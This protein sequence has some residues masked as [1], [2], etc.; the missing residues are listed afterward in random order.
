LIFVS[1]SAIDLDV[2]KALV[3]LLRTALHLPS[4][5]I[6]CT[7]VD[8]NRLPVGVDTAETLRTEI[9]AAEAFIGIVTPASARSSYV[10]FELGA[11]WGA[12]RFI[13][14]VIARG[15]PHSQL[16]GPLTQLNALDLTSAAQVHQLLENLSTK[17]DIRLEPA[18]ALNDPIS[19]LV[20]AASANYPNEAITKSEGAA[21]TQSPPGDS[22]SLQ[23]IE[24]LQ[25]FVEFHDH[26]NADDVVKR[27]ELRRHKA[28]YHL[29]RLSKLRLIAHHDEYRYGKPVY[30]ITSEGRAT[31]VHMGLL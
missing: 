18:S 26:H 17:L 12:D 20:S 7:S 15:L 11:R 8:G 29:E 10:L 4:P 1:H 3:Y 28:D 2:A 6:R 13:A 14:P 9:L 19:Q 27:F 25:M 22:P 30:F 21:L 24:I 16:P 31:L 23:E 5:R